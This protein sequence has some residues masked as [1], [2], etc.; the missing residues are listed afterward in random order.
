MDLDTVHAVN[1]MHPWIKIVWEPQ[2]VTTYI[3]CGQTPYQV[4]LNIKTQ[5]LP[6]LTGYHIVATY[7]NQQKLVGTWYWG[8]TDHYNVCNSQSDTSYQLMV[9]HA[10]CSKYLENL[11]MLRPCCPH[12]TRHCKTRPRSG[13]Q[14]DRWRH[15][16][17]SSPKRHAWHSAWITAPYMLVD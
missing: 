16:R 4:S 3:S 2:D 12:P 17:R 14:C 8:F 5:M 11:L 13:T 9:Q 10:K 6:N 1:S 7:P 15:R